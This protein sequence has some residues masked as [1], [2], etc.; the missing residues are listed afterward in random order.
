MLCAHVVT[1]SQMALIRLCCIYTDGCTVHVVSPRDD[2]MDDVMDYV[3][4]SH[5]HQFCAA[6]IY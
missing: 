3:C 5:A 4:T 6:L 1:S 2:V